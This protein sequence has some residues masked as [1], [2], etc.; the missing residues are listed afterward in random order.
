MRTDFTAYNED[1]DDEEDPDGPLASDIDH[2]DDDDGDDMVCPACGKG[3]AID[4]PKCP[5]CGDWIRPVASR[6]G[7]YRRWTKIVAILLLAPVFLY[8]IMGLLSLVR[9]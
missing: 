7:S 1:E 5:H 9:K 2:A 3:V 8:L 4:T 6:G